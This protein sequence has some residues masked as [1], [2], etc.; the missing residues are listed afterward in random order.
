MLG[1][2]TRVNKLRGSDERFSDIDVCWCYDDCRR[3]ATYIISTLRS[4]LMS[5][6]CEGQ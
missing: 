2:I 5:L 4:P 3:Y 6:V 1:I